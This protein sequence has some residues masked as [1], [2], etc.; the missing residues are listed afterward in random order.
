MS[1]QQTPSANRIHIGLFGKRNAGKSSLFNALLQQS[2][3]I[4]SPVKGTTTDPVKK[5]MELLPLG[6]ILLI[7]T[8]GLDD[9]GTLGEARKEKALQTLTKVDIALLVL[10]CQ[11][12]MTEEDRSI[13]EELLQHKTPTLLVWNKID[14]ITTKEECIKELSQ[15]SKHWNLPFVFVSAISSSLEEL[16]QKIG[17]LNPKMA[18]PPLIQDLI[19]PGD[20]IILVVPID[21]SAPKGRLILP[22]QQVI[23]EIL[24]LGAV[25]ILLT[26]Q[27][28]SPC[29]AAFSQRPALVVC[30]SQVFAEVEKAL[31]REIP[32]TSFSIL[33]A[34]RKGSLKVFS[35]G[36]SYLNQL[37]D[38]DSILISEG[39]T[40]HRQC[41]DIGTVKLPKWIRDYTKKELHFSFTSGQEFPKQLT[42]FKLI[43]HCGSCMLKESEMRSRIS[44][45]QKA[46]VPITNYGICIAQ[47]HG[48]L[49]RSLELFF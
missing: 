14:L 35:E 6:P 5:A 40:H 23:R 7:D 42:D 20:F 4:V 34:R 36:A 46:K 38:G 10:D 11:L 19:H 48:I 44:L 24:D 22:Q 43:V 39:C 33:F 18:E 31:P 37:K 49:K 15:E 16:K 45:A 41:E 32:L 26:P 21:K 8:P 27:Q 1:L 12:G 17:E 25:S 30:D 29:F 3:S 13:L 2:L 9:V 47:I 28:L